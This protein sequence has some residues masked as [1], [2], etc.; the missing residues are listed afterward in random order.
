MFR[1]RRIALKY[2]IVKS[3]K[4]IGNMPFDIHIAS[5]VHMMRVFFVC[6]KFA[7][8]IST[9]SEQMKGVPVGRAVGIDLGTTYSAV[10]VLDAAGGGCRI[11]EF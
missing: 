9:V 10:A 6:N 3:N 2:I 7:C 5:D 1:W 11:T 4:T 8:I